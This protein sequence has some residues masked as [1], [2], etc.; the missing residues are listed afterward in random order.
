L[1]REAWTNLLLSHRF[2]IRCFDARD[3]AAAA[4]GDT[5]CES[6]VRLEWFGSVKESV[7]K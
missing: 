2:Q 6:M 3:F 5:G 7:E 1:A 4:E